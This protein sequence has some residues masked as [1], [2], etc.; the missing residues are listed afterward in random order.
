MRIEKRILIFLLIPLLFVSSCI[1]FKQPHL[2]IKKYTLEYE[3]PGFTKKERL[4]YTIKV[5]S[6]SVAPIYNTTR[7]IYSKKPYEIDSYIYHKWISNPGELVTHLIGRDIRNSG[8]FNGVLLPGERIKDFSYRL[9]GTIEDFY[10]SDE[11]SN[12]KGVLSLSISL[13]SEGD[14]ETGDK[15]IFQKTYKA[16]ENCEEKNPAAL[17]RAMSRALK[18]VSEELI[19]DLYM[20]LKLEI[21]N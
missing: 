15:I 13:I 7:I 14:S 19:E 17:A 10:E 9:G 3:S 5:D 16:T 18:K 21:Q 2:S 11:K 8:L 4:D 20:S 1:S 6:F 12:W